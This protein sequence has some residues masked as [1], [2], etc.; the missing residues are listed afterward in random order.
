MSN[1]DCTKLFND[2]SSIWSQIEI[3]IFKLN[4]LL[5]FQ[6]AS[7][8][9]VCKFELTTLPGAYDAFMIGAFGFAAVSTITLL[10]YLTNNLLRVLMWHNFL[11]FQGIW[12]YSLHHT[13]FLGC[14]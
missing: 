7:A 14:S 3:K 2:V 10:I 11:H 8:C 1:V 9:E 13:A 4:F 6:Y 5:S 12:T